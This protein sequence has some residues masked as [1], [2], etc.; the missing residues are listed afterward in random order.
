MNQLALYIFYVKLLKNWEFL[1]FKG[2]YKIMRYHIGNHFID[3]LKNKTKYLQK[4]TQ[5][6]FISIRFIIGYR[7]KR[8]WNQHWSTLFQYSDWHDRKMFKSFSNDECSKTD[9]FWNQVQELF[10]HF[11]RLIIC[12]SKSLYMYFLIFFHQVQVFVDQV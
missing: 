6:S 11:A 5:K 10:S 2:K 3:K 8:I 1:L 9:I 7:N 4:L 12:V